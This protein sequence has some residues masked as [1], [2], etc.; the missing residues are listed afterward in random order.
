MK[1]WH[2]VFLCTFILFELLFNAASF[3]LI[4]HN[5]NLSQQKEIERG[6]AE[7][8]IVG[9]QIQTDWAYVYSMDHQ[10]ILAGSAQDFIKNNAGKYTRYFDG[11]RVFVEILDDQDNTVFTNFGDGLSGSRPEL[12]GISSGSRQY[13][14]RDIGDKTYLF[15]SGGLVLDN[16]D[17]KLSYIRDISDVYADKSSQVS[18]FFKMNI[19]I[20]VILALGLYG[21]IWF[22]TRSVRTLNKSAQTIAGGD[23]S[24]RVPVLSGDEIGVLATSFNQMAEAVESKVEELEVTARN[25]QNFINCLTHEL[26]TPLTTIIGYA[27]FLRTAKYNEEVFF[28]ALTY[29]YM[30]G[31][32]LESL[33]FKLLD[34]LLLGNETPDLTYEDVSAICADIEEAMRPQLEKFSVTLQA[35]L[36]PGKVLIE[37][38][39]FKLLCTNLLDNAAK[40]SAP[41]SQISLRGR[42]TGDKRYALEIEDEGI[43]I[44]EEDIPKIFEPFFVVDKARSKAHHGAGLGLAICAQIVRLHKADLTI[45]SRLGEGTIVRITFPGLYN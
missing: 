24:Q 14:L 43:G 18:L 34:L 45:T 37:Q 38:D 7:Q 21:L 33:S 10:L 23:Y 36:E 28:K 42:I 40:A 5:F 1:L 35:E 39:L 15:V 6:L 11:S 22:L 25:R 44:P 17:F 32:R 3:Y 30:E 9:S 29:I 41:S 12:A 4:E 26:K 13:I 20:T 16:T 19:A 31:K 27:D 2:K 8:Q